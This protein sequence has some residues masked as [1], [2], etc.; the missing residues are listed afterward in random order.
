MLTWLGDVSVEYLFWNS[1]SKLEC[2]TKCPYGINVLIFISLSFRWSRVYTQSRNF[3]FPRVY[4]QNLK[5]LIIIITL[6][7]DAEFTLS[8][9]IFIFSEFTLRIWSEKRIYFLFGYT[10]QTQNLSTNCIWKGEFLLFFRNPVTFTSMLFLS[11]TEP[12]E[13]SAFVF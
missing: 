2:E 7:V 10:T 4:T 6:F 9:E 11:K 13:S 1:T 8:H 3:H 12:Q 5:Y